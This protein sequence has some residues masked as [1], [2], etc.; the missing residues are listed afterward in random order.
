LKNQDPTQPA[1]GMQFVTQLA[2]FS[3]V[4]QSLAMRT[5]LDTIK[6][7]YVGASATTSDA[8]SAAAVSGADSTSTNNSTSTSNSAGSQLF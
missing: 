4:E 1:D 2:E 5:D 3:N 8:S 6:Q 7:K